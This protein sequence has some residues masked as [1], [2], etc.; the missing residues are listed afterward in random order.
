V[1]NAGAADVQPRGTDNPP[2][3]VACPRP[4]VTDGA[5]AVDGAPTPPASPAIHCGSIEAPCPSPLAKSRSA[6]IRRP[7]IVVVADTDDAGEA[8]PCSA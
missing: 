1:R 2:T 7:R 6:L 8:S 3:V 5:A 4:A